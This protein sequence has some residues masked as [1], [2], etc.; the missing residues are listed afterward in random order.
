MCYKEAAMQNHPTA[1]Y[2]LGLLHYRRYLS[3][4]KSKEIDLSE[5]F[6]LLRQAAQ[7]GLEEARSAMSALKNEVETRYMAHL[8]TASMVE[9]D[10]ENN[11]R[12]L[13]CGSTFRKAFS[14]PHNFSYY[15]GDSTKSA[16]NLKFEKQITNDSVFF[17]VGD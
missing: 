7:Q 1:Q 15:S 14:E 9:R 8:S 17:Y 13:T 16:N 5:A 10:K 3:N 2:N 12:L 4:E 11:S 6:S